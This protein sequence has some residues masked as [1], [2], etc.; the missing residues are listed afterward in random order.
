MLIVSND[1]NT[2]C[3]RRCAKVFPVGRWK[4]YGRLST[5]GLCV[6]SPTTCNHDRSIAEQFS[7][8][9][10]ILIH[11]LSVSSMSL[12]LLLGWHEVI[13]QVAS[14]DLL[15]FSDSIVPCWRRGW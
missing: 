3:R 8:L 12:R 9:T 11:R 10:T 2:K 5:A 13:N 6:L 1:H 4:I 15:I 14:G 7:N